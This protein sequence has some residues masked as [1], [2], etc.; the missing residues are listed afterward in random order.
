[1]ILVGTAVRTVWKPDPRFLPGIVF[2]A[3]TL[4]DIA[5][6][7]LGASVSV[8][9]LVTTGPALIGGVALVV[10]IALFVSY[11]LGRSLGL[12]HR[13]AVLVACGNSIC[14]N[15]RSRRPRR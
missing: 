4:L 6:V 14:G 10:V 3:K 7:L 11:G 5:V 2:G 1:M 12:P 13:M 9:A 15:R 8:G